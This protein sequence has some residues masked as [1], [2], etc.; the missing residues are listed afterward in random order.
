MVGS[1]SSLYLHRNRHVSTH[2][3]TLTRSHTY[4]MVSHLIPSMHTF[5]SCH[6]NVCLL[7]KWWQSYLLMN[8]VQTY[9]KYVGICCSWASCHMPVFVVCHSASIKCKHVILINKKYYMK[10]F[11]LLC[12]KL[13]FLCWIWQ[14]NNAHRLYSLW[15]S[16]RFYALPLSLSL[17]LYVDINMNKNARCDFFTFFFFW[18]TRWKRKQNILEKNCGSNK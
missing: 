14:N 2:T 16:S 7:P 4:A 3:H 12:R 11:V 18:R 6:G 17:S 13:F 15:L 9:S 10:P 1:S 5:A 8:N